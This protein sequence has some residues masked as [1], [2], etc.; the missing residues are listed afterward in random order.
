M[1]LSIYYFK[2]LILG[3]PETTN[4]FVTLAF[5][6]PGNDTGSSIEWYTEINV[7]ENK[8]ELDI[9][10]ITDFI[11]NDMDNII[12]TAD[13]IIYFINPMNKDDQDF[14][15]IVLPIINSVKR[16]IPLVIIYNDNSGIIPMSINEL[17]DDLWINHPDL[18]GFVNLSPHEFHQVLQCLCDAIITGDTPLNIENA[19]MRYPIFIQL[20]NIYYKNQLFEKSARAIRKAAMIADIFNKQNYY[21][22][23]EKSALLFSEADFYLEASEIMQNIDKKK[24]LNFKTL[25]ARGLLLEGNKLFNKRKYV[26]SAKKYLEAAHWSAIELKDQKITE[27]AFRT[28][29]SSWISACKVENAF[30]ILDGLNHEVALNIL[31]QIS[32][33]IKASI[34][35][36]EEQ[37]NYISARDQLYRTI[38]IYQR[39]GL[40]E[41]LE[42][43]TNHLE[44][45]LVKLIDV[46]L[47][48]N[49][50]YAAKQTYDEIENLWESYNVKRT[51]LDDQLERLI[52][53]FLDDTDFGM[54]S[55][56]MNKIK[57]KPLKKKLTE[58][59]SKAE[60]QYKESKKKTVEENIRKGLD[61]LRIFLDA[62]EQITLELNKEIIE[63]SKNLIEEQGYE[64]AA[65]NLKNL[66]EYYRK[67]GK[68]GIQDNVLMEAQN[69]LLEGNETKLFFQ[70][71]DLMSDEAQ[72]KFLDEKFTFIKQKLMDFKEVMDFIHNEEVYEKMITIYRDQMLYEQAAIISEQFIELIQTTM[73]SNIK[74][75]PDQQGITKIRNL[76]KKIEIISAKYLDDKI[77]DL[78]EIYKEIIEVAL[79]N[80]DFS[81]AHEFCD[82]IFNKMLKSEL[83]KRIDKKESEKSLL[84][85]KQLEKDREKEE[86]KDR[87]II[88][89]RKAQEALQDKADQIRQR[90]ALKRIYFNEALENLQTNDLDNAIINYKNTVQKF[91]DNERYNIAG[92]SLLMIILIYL[93]QENINAVKR[94]LEKTKQDLSVLGKL[95]SELFPFSLSE[96]LYDVK[97]N[98]EEE[99]YL[100]AL[101]FTKNVALFE[102]EINFLMKIYGDIFP[103]EDKHAPV[104]K[105]NFNVL[106][107]DMNTLA[108]RIQMNKQERSKRKLM[109]NEYWKLSLDDLASNRYTMAVDGYFQAITKLAMKK[110]TKQ[111]VISL[112]IGSLTQLKIKSI[113]EV[114]TN[115]LKY[116]GKLMNFEKEVQ[117]IPEIKFMNLL[118]TCFEHNQ[119][120]L[121]T[122]GVNTLKERLYFFDPEIDLLR[123]FS[124][125]EFESNIEPES[126][127]RKQLG[128]L[129]TRDV[130]L[131]QEF[132][133][134]QKKTSDLRTD[135]LRLLN[136]RNAMRR[137]YYQDTLSLLRSKNFKS[138]AINYLELAKWSSEKGDYVSSSL[139]LLLYGLASIKFKDEI[140]NIQEN[141]NQFLNSLGLNKRLVEDTFP[142][143]FILFLI[144]LKL[145]HI[146]KYDS[147]L[148]EML[149]LLPL[150][151]EEQILIHF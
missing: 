35:F 27:D 34:K 6:N 44:K 140:A 87:I 124:S 91:I 134:L 52:T 4:S 80:D 130:R 75:Q 72:K 59:I 141:V 53:L 38:A 150:F 49:E 146:Q 96:Y 148:S 100:K 22:I 48:S 76:L 68:E 93:S 114:K 51:S 136:K 2:L 46:Q 74:E 32:E 110:F 55:L 133:S 111:A 83:N 69:I 119:S 126:L 132:A 50:K 60:D 61:V 131:E 122:Y 20:A 121:I 107:E 123:S 105:I 10:L 118:F 139:H 143:K 115:F 33:K 71:H 29:I 73:L 116:L 97:R 92:I 81:I 66:A 99:D 90:N 67:I 128:E 39:E 137:R 31:K 106:R 89:R 86:V 3:N 129:K 45:I 11:N 112:I 21:I 26:E 79:N 5:D 25:Y 109:K 151:E 64:K 85:L 54:T 103:S 117:K 84:E 95:I 120:D 42:S 43:F 101:N 138:I 15:E 113:S 94:L 104:E 142:V 8:C 135:Q 1:N 41:I 63:K 7:I 58:M 70:Y 9:N 18:E 40:F 13:G 127:S 102:E 62:E 19:W 24:A 16:G 145:N 78:D 12:P 14:F 147:K 56:L 125:E 30:Q 17:L 37:E 88:I 65:L 77:F 23:A 98:L 28:A 47:D 149:E 82:K 57:S 36:L 144:D 108:E